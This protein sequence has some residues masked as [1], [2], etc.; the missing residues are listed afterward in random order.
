M[1]GAINIVSTV[2]PDYPNDGEKFTFSG[3]LGDDISL[4]AKIHLDFVP[5]LISEL[6]EKGND[7]VWYI[8]IADLP[9]LI[10]DQKEYYERVA[11]SKKEYLR[12]CSISAKKIVKRVNGSANVLTFSDFYGN[13]KIDY[14]AIQKKVAD[15][16]LEESKTGR[17]RTKFN[18]F[19][20][21]RKEL[22]E[23]FR[24]RRISQEE[25][26]KA[27]AHGMSLYAT[28]G[29]LLR[30]IFKEKNL[31]IINHA[32]PSICNFFSCNFVKDYV[33]TAAKSQKFPVGII[34]ADLY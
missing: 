11:G 31:V 9:E 32:T 26:K 3:D 25:L 4:T 20:I 27:S 10:D 17:F 28:H 6:K 23:K 29:T 19:M 8:I 12:R 15:L 7:V 22:A 13:M 33:A 18:S 16:I 34:D 30:V 2:C 1:R 5:E 21:Q 14:M 24:G